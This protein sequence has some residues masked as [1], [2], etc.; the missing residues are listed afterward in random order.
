LRYADLQRLRCD[1][2]KARDFLIAADWHPRAEPSSQSLHDCAARQL[3]L[4]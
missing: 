3:E 1:L 4:F 2:R